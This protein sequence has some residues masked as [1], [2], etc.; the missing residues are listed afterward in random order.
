MIVRCTSC[1]SAFAVDD[2]KVEDKKFAFTCPKCDYENIVDNRR[3]SKPSFTEEAIIDEAYEEEKE[4]E[5]ITETAPDRGKADKP[6]FDDLTLEDT[7]DLSGLAE[8]ERPEETMKSMEISELPPADDMHSEIPLDDLALESELEDLA[9]PDKEASVADKAIGVESVRADKTGFEELGDELADVA[10]DSELIQDEME[11]QDE[12]GEPVKLEDVDDIDK[13]LEEDDRKREIVDDFEPFEDDTVKAAS[14]SPELDLGLGED[15]KTEE[16]FRAEDK[17]DEESITIDLDTLDIDIEESKEEALVGESGSAQGAAGS[18]MMKKRAATAVAS[19]DENITIDLDS[20]DIDLKDEQEVLT[21]ES[22]EELGL[23]LSDFSEET[24]QELEDVATAPKAREDENI[25]LDLDSLDISLEE[26][27][28]IKQGE[29][30]DDEKLTLEDAGLTLDELTTDELS[31]VSTKAGMEG[32]DEEDISVSLDE[33]DS[34]LDVVAIER[35]LKEAESILS[36]SPEAEDD[37]LIVDELSDLPE[38]DLEDELSLT[39]EGTGERPAFPSRRDDELIGLDDSERISTKKGG[40]QKVIPDMATHGAVNFSIDYSIKY[41]RIGAALRILGL[42]SIGL[43]PHYLV[44]LIYTVLSVILGFINHIVV[45]A[46]EKN[47]EDFSGI[48][49]NTLRYL[50][51]ISASAIG[52]VEEMPI[53]AGRYNIDYP[54]QLRINYPLRSQRLLA[55]LRLSCVGILLFTLPHLIILGVLGLMTPFVFIVGI[56]SV[57]ITGGWPHVLFDFMTRYYRY[58]ARVMAFIIGIVDVYPKFKL[59]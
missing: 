23:D 47:I 40:L 59:D 2:A 54:L 14:K 11:L 27:D 44:L 5:G 46:T 32:A 58:W 36:E 22:H 49:E 26:N 21:G 6:Q 38:I 13:L 8:P 48:H 39:E 41:S 42:F 4:P 34:D 45:I 16:M 1:N 52:I 9:I 10:S 17:K 7:G 56:L 55:F 35:E 31:S 12:G 50:L 51:S 20:L 29:A 28:E 53:F 24:L 25:T 18:D 43:I 3:Q 19:D 33:I 57:L 37:L 30:L 15:I